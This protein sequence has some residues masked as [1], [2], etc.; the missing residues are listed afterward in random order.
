MVASSRKTV[1][2]AFPRAA[3]PALAAAAI[4]AALLAAPLSV[5][6]ADSTWV[7][8]YRAAQAAYRAGDL[9]G[10]RAGLMR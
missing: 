7:D 6:R 3:A 1:N 9:Q 10:F 5:A 4:A 2:G 8:R